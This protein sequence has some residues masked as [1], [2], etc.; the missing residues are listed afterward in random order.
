[1]G[2]G[3]AVAQR[4]ATDPAAGPEQAQALTDAVD[5]AFAHGVSTT[6]LVGGIIMAVGTVIV[7]AVLPGRRGGA[8]DRPEGEPT[9]ATADPEHSDSAR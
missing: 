4:L 6:S 7:L 9:A 3:L 2:G 8:E 1:V 5:R